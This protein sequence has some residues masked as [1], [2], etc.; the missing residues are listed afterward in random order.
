MT[1]GVSL[2]PL[3]AGTSF[4]IP[5]NVFKP[6]LTDAPSTLIV[7]VPIKPKV[8]T[9]KTPLK[10]T[11]D[12]KKVE[13]SQR[14]NTIFM[15]DLKG[16]LLGKGKATPAFIGLIIGGATKVAIGTAATTETV[17]GTGSTATAAGGA[18]MVGGT[19]SAA[20][21]VA[22]GLVFAAVGIWSAVFPDKLANEPDMRNVKPKLKPLPQTPKNPAL[23]E[24]GGSRKIKVDNDNG[25]KKTLAKM[26]IG[27]QL[28]QLRKSIPRDSF[29]L[30]KLEDEARRTGRSVEQVIK[31]RSEA[32]AKSSHNLS[33]QIK[34]SDP[35]KV[36]N[37]F[38][39]LTP[40][41]QAAL[42]ENPSVFKEISKKL[43][44]FK[45]AKTVKEIK[46]MDLVEAMALY[47]QK[48]AAQ[49]AA[50]HPDIRRAYE[51]KPRTYEVQRIYARS[52]EAAIIE[53]HALTDAQRRALNNQIKQAYYGKMY[54][55]LDH[56][57][58]QPVYDMPR[59]FYAPHQ[60]F[61]LFNPK[62]W[63]IRFLPDLTLPPSKWDFN[64]W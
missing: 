3:L 29:K 38:H 46:N 41:Q 43:A 57:T 13:F 49:K 34:M 8:I 12:G 23:G 60:K 47:R 28:E 37:W 52:K 6:S 36:A 40:E 27:E 21:L 18:G 45:I 22:G 2:Q 39:N 31:A 7:Q 19:L 30:E 16:A 44:D 55:N 63:N 50:L 11:V 9:L 1:T 35:A 32:I 24:T 61:N 64:R 5:Q 53:F 20:A 14:G 25:A 62:T 58:N 26:D 51:A 15:R 59:D 48:T 10:R 42:R 4:S 33:K 17:I 56:Y 54:F